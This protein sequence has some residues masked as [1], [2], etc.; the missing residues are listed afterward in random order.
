MC[1]VFELPCAAGLFWAAAMVTAEY[2]KLVGLGPGRR[3]ATCG[4][5]VLLEKLG[6]RHLRSLGINL[7]EGERLYSVAV[8]CKQSCECP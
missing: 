4:L 8:L 6:Q 1:E 5:Q 7:N 2:C 3:P